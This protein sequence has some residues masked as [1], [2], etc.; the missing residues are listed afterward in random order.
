M[1]ETS[2]TKIFDFLVS[3][4]NLNWA[5]RK[6]Q[7]LYRM[8]DG[9]Y[10]IAEV[11][12][13]ELDLEYQL[14]SIQKDFTSLSYKLKPLVLL[15]QP[16]KSDADGNPQ[17]RQSF[18][19]AVRDQVAWIAIANAIGP[20]L[21]SKMPAWSYG[22]RLYKAAWYEIQD[23]RHRLET[24]PYRHSSGLL[25]RRFKHSWPL[26]RR[27]VSLT[28]RAMVNGL[29]SGEQ[30][31]NS[32]Q[33]ALNFAERP[34]YL[35]KGYWPKDSGHKLFYAS[36]DLERF[37]PNTKTEAVLR[38]IK[39]NLDGIDQEDNLLALLG[40]ML[41]FRIASGRSSYLRDPICQPRTKPGRFGGIPTG[42][43]VAGFLSNV[44]MLPLD[45]VTDVRIR[46]RKEVAHF[47]FVDDHVVLAYRFEELV[48]WI[49][50]YK[51]DLERFSIGPS[52]SEKKYSP[53]ALVTVINDKASKDIVANV[54][55]ECEID[56]RR[57][58][59]LMT[60]TLALVSDLAG[61]GFEIMP[62]QAREQ[63]LSELEWLLLANLPEDEI[64]SDTR[65][66]FAAGRI[67]VLVP[68]SFKHS[69]E[70]V[71]S[72]RLLSNLRA[73]E[74][75]DQRLIAEAERTANKQRKSQANA[76][77]RRVNH[78]F[79]LLL[80]A[81]HDY[82]DKPRLFIRALDYCRTTGQRGTPELLRWV[83]SELENSSRKPLAT[84]LGPLAVQTIARHIVTA[85]FDMSDQQLLERQRRA[86]R[87]YIMSLAGKTAVR[88][89]L[90]Q[91][92]N[93]EDDTF[94]G[95][96]SRNALLAAVAYATKVISRK[97]SKRYVE[98]LAT[99][100][101][102]PDLTA[103]SAEWRKRTGSPIGVWVHWLDS[104]R[105]DKDFGPGL[106]WH[107]TRDSH[108]P[109]YLFDRRSLRKGPA[110][111]SLKG[112]SYWS[113]HPKRLKIS[114]A[115]WLLEQQR[116][117]HPI[118][119]DQ[120]EERPPV[121]RRLVKHSRSLAKSKK[122][123]L[124][125]WVSAIAAFSDE[126]PRLGEWTA[127]EI[128]RQLVSLV[129]VFQTGRL[130]ILDELHP[131]NVLVPASWLEDR[132]PGT[133]TLPRWTWESWRQKVHEKDGRNIGVVKVPISDFR[134]DL[135]DG[136]RDLEHTWLS[137]LRGIGLLLLGLCCRDFSLP[138]AWNI[139]GAERDVGRYV[140]ARLEDATISSRT[141][142]IIEASLLS[143]SAETALIRFNPQMFFGSRKTLSVNDT[144]TDPPFIIDVKSLLHEISAAQSV[145][146]K[147]QISVLN[148]APRQL[149]PMSVYQLTRL[150]VPLN[151]FPDDAE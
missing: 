74:K 150:A 40:S 84:Y 22:H 110:Q 117:S 38:G 21:D 134:R 118:N 98:L 115:G 80:Q 112:S 66:A 120:T 51:K 2:V 64:R 11:S 126:D 100:L 65:A 28:A 132:P 72:H 88:R 90:R 56:G 131:S 12:A 111:M 26:F 54:R 14:R 140:R 99:T 93:L 58:A 17:L 125:S 86:A 142:G 42:L 63:R 87:S 30:L 69:T 25:Y 96:A 147:T 29:N 20:T 70:L 45:L 85:A 122:I 76:D 141:Q 151:S 46:E 105:P 36:I 50:S 48:E 39:G 145:L 33:N 94:A 128:V 129:E 27:H 7:R 16:K 109:D 32:E 3:T 121:F 37:Y 116:S 81:F 149:V 108:E 106:A 15:P 67:S 133:F 60:K 18:H 144:A 91:I 49:R 55:S 79:K 61:A 102:A 1:A 24:G 73:A 83:V 127:L 119:V 35:N 104:L 62:D 44:A 41:S 9:V 143:R 146:Q 59:K 138:S 57:P 95:L 8:A 130:E 89:S 52:V 139:R 113:Q 137:R 103:P 53:P 136:N 148:H 4:E 124:D 5:W 107:L 78:Y 6:A 114:D 135:T 19:V 34:A 43:M 75:L 23:G 71:E 101:E 123:S 47:R 82:P 10:D 77:L 68:M 92:V 97:N 31:D 13:F